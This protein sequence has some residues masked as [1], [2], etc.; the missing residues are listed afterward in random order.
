MSDGN[1]PGDDLPDPSVEPTAVIPATPGTPPGPAGI[2]PVGPPP[3][4]P[5]FGDSD[6]DD[7]SEGNGAGP[8]QP[9]WVIPVIVGIIA[10]AIVLLALILTR[11]SDDDDDA[12]PAVDT[13]TTTMAPETTLEIVTVTSVE[14]TTTAPETSTTVA[15]ETTVE[16]TTTLAPETTVAPT[17]TPPTTTPPTTAPPTTAPPEPE[18]P[19]AQPAGNIGAN[20]ASLATVDGEQTFAVIGTCTSTPTVGLQAISSALANESGT[21][22]VVDVYLDEGGDPFIEVTDMTESIAG[23]IYGQDTAGDNSRWSADISDPNTIDQVTLTALD[24]T[25]DPI[26][27]SMN[28][29]GPTEC[30]RGFVASPSP[31]PEE[32]P[33]DFIDQFDP[34]NPGSGFAVLAA[35]NDATYVT[36]GG[37]LIDIFFATASDEFNSSY[38]VDLPANSTFWTTPDG[39]TANQ[40]IV[41]QKGG[42]GDTD[43][44]TQVV[45]FN[46]DAIGYLSVRIQPTSG[47]G[48]KLIDCPA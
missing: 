13:T 27:L 38:S 39:V 19:V 16:A 10:L 36:S 17:T 2:P 34:P 32:G 45:N 8:G 40:Q 46:N 7:P 26:A 21:V 48:L 37:G 33:I 6:S 25:S 23:F 42:G 30:G 11:G 14:T 9:P 1:L 5:P 22:Y 15:P 44:A 4:A 20:V 12:L 24:G 29:N 43:Y 41:F 3:S 18:G 47:G 31:F 28:S 35:C